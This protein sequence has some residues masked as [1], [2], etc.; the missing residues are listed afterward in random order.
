VRLR[1]DDWPRLPLEDHHRWWKE[2][3]ARELRQI[4][5]WR[6]DPIGAADYLPSTEDEYDSYLGGLVDLLR[7]AASV[8]EIAHY[9]HEIEIKQIELPTSDDKRR[10]VAHLTRD[11]YPNSSA[12]WRNA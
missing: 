2:A 6:W 8:D 7:R 12:H 1:E 9:L 5:L 3:G 4:L 11:W 10:Y